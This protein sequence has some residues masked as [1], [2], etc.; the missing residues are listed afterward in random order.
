MSK[1]KIEPIPNG[2]YKITGSFT[3]YNEK[4]ELIS[5]EKEIYLCRC[6]GSKNKPFCDGTHNKIGFKSK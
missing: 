1:A 4:G 6:G 2:P 3:L 5:N